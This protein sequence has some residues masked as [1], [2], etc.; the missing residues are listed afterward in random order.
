MSAGDPTEVDAPAGP[1]VPGVDEPGGPGAAAG[2]GPPGKPVR[3]HPRRRRRIIVGTLVALM[4]VWWLGWHSPVTQVKHVVVHAPRGISEASI[5]LASGITTA[6]HV[7][8]VDAQAV[9]L[10]LMTAIPAIADVEVGRTLPAT[11]SLTVT[12]REPFA[13]VRAGRGFYVMDSGGVVFD[14]VAGA[15]DLPVITAASDVGRDASREVLLS[16]PASLRKDVR[17][18]GA[19]TSDDVTLELRD[20]ATVRWG[21][22]ED[23]E[24]KAGVLAGLVSVKA[25]RYDV[26]AP[27]QPTTSGSVDASSQS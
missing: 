10:A 3:E 24:L 2:A 15:K 13:A 16:M 9:R 18:V 17:Q 6:D 5:R 7:P 22:A 11:L 21:S 20:G 27:L 14:K 23:A 25:T 4:A 1:P 19:G 12:A 8:A 26:S